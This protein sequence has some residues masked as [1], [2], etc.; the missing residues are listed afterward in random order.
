M[1]MKSFSLPAAAV[2][3]L[4]LAACQP[5]AEEPVPADTAPVM[6]PDPKMDPATN[7]AV[8]DVAPGEAPAP[9]TE[10]TPQ[11]NPGVGDPPPTL[12]T[13]PTSPPEM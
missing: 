13:E 5:S 7:G 9:T 3:A 12:P 10:T 1:S 6:D 11:V 4:A 8:A 2:A